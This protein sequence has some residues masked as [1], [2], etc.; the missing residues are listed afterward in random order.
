MS[1]TTFREE[2]PERR[3]YSAPGAM[4]NPEGVSHKAPAA[5]NNGRLRVTPSVFTIIIKDG[6]VLLLRRYNTSWLDG[7]Y[8]LPAG[9]LEDQE[10]LKNGAVR[11]LKEEANITAAPSDLK[12][13]HIYQNH[14]R[15]DTPHYGYMFL[16]KKWSGTPRIMEKNK[17]DDMGWFKLEDLPEKTSAYAREALKNINGNEVTISYYS[18]GSMN[19]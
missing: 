5:N 9:H 7:W 18:P 8:D 15:P 12:L 14:D 2:Q 1:N 16:A 6:K 13:V 11:E 10:K 4:R 3:I 17:C 19:G